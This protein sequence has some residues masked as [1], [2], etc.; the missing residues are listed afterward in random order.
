[1][2]LRTWIAAVL[3]AASPLSLTADTVEPTDLAPITHRSASLVVVGTDGFSQ[4][5]SPADLEGFPTYAM[6]TT[7]PW[8]ETPARFEGVLL[9]DVLKAHG[10]DTVDSVTVMAENDFAS[11]FSREVFSA[12]N[13]LIA[14][15]VDGQAHTRRERG[16][17]Q[18]VIH[19]D[20]YTA[21]SPLRERH[22]VWMAARIEETTE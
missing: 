10:L 21:D 5:Y 14:T 2:T 15:R 12:Y 4:T 8:R 9:I 18:F 6:T 20:D 19:A 13:I 22:F 1:M 7:T 17:L 3:L 16:P 11:E